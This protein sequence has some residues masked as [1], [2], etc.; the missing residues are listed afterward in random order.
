[1]ALALGQRDNAEERDHERPESVFSTCGFTNSWLSVLRQQ[2]S[3][4]NDLLSEG[5]V[6]RINLRRILGFYRPIEGE[7]VRGVIRCLDDIPKLIVSR[8]G[9]TFNQVVSQ[10]KEF[11]RAEAGKC[12][13]DKFFAEDTVD[14]F[15]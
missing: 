9:G 2:Y 8:V 13:M 1:V 14:L 15:M 6:R 3:R 12:G 10:G 7:R 5:A 4:L 11:R